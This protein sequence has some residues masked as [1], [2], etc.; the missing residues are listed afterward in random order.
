MR[1]WRF[2]IDG[3]SLHGFHK[4]MR[5]SVIYDGGCIKFSFPY[6]CK[7]PDQYLT[8]SDRSN[9]I[10]Y[11]YHSIHSSRLRHWFLKTTH[12]APSFDILSIE[13]HAEVV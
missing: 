7:D 9:G 5:K 12:L 6:I 10:G 1:R 8:P 2:R 3:L 4:V 13:L 11:G